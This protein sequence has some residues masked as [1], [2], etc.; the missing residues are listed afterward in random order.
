M[1]VS[2]QQEIEWC[3]FVDAGDKVNEAIHILDAVK[4]LLEEAML[5][6]SNCSDDYKC[7]VAHDGVE[8][9]RRMV[10]NAKKYLELLKEKHF[11]DP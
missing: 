5:C 7:L 6:L 2:E 9:A 1:T 4:M 8:K 11:E 3:S 10:I